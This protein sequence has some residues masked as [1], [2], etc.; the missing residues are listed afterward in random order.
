[1]TTA[2]QLIEKLKLEKHIE[3]GFFKRIYTCHH[4][5]TLNNQQR[6]L[7]SAIHYL[8]E[9][10]DFSAFHKIKSDE[11]LSFNYGSCLTI[12]IIN[13]A[14]DLKKIIL[15]STD[16][17]YTYPILA[18]QWFAAE[19]NDKSSFTLMTCFVSPSFDFQDFELADRK[20]LISLFPQH[21]QIIKK[22]TR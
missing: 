19:V 3:G 6:N 22:L 15:G 5:T 21:E 9:G 11:L 14:G 20:K 7:S 4:N 17:V 16:N 8:L 1:M 12:Y 18:K 2:T 10:N 13:E